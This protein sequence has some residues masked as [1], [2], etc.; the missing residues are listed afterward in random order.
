MLPEGFAVGA[1]LGVQGLHPGA[2]AVGAGDVQTGHNAID[3]DEGDGL[4]AER[5]S[6]AGSLRLAGVA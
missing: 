3:G 5:G 4:L 2:D 1:S 6:M